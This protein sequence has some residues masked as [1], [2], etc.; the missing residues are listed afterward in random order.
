MLTISEGGLCQVDGA[1]Y[2]TLWEEEGEES[3]TDT[4]ELFKRSSAVAS[5]IT[6]DNPSQWKELFQS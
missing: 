2:G 6:D 1:V 3:A 4:F 5:T